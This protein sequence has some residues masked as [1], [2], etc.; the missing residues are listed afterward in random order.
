MALERGI[1]V[2]CEVPAAVSIGECKAVTLAARRSQAIYMMAE[3]YTYSRQN[4]IVRELVRAGRL[5]E[6]YYAEA[7]YLHEYKALG[8]QKGYEAVAKKAGHEGGD[9]FGMLDFHD[10]VLGLR[11]NPID[12]DA[13]MDMT[14]PGLVSQQS[15]SQNRDKPYAVYRHNSFDSPA[16]FC[17]SFFPPPR[18]VKQP[19]QSITKPGAMRRAVPAHQRVI[20]FLFFMNFF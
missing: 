6:P 4:V 15:I 5:G 20:I 14:L 7:E 13:S 10:T 2:L 18:T 8:E 9:F 11:S 1:H 12:I 3:N 17:Q 19:L 16:N